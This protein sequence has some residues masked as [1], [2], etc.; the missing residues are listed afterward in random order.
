MGIFR[1]KI[2]QMQTLKALLI[3]AF[4]YSSDSFSQGR[5]K[6]KGEKGETECKDVKDCFRKGLCQARFALS[7]W[8]P[9]GC[10]CQKNECEREDGCEN[11]NECEKK[12]E[13]CS[14]ENPCVC[15]GSKIMRAGGKQSGI[16][17]KKED[18]CLPGFK[19]NDPKTDECL[20]DKCS[21]PIGHPRSLFCWPDTD[22]NSYQEVYD[23]D[24]DSKHDEPDEPQEPEEY[25]NIRTDH[26]DYIVT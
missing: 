13:G 3:F 19:S 5:G 4:L 6:K 21:H 2:Q 25:Q 14:K 24:S 7:S 12:V 20:T 16:C 23:E 8:Q 26:N 11:D 1:L 18:Q 15:G 9:P 22:N 10:K 17:L